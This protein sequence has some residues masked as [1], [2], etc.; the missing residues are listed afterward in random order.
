MMGG[1]IFRSLW[2]SY[3]RREREL[4][5]KFD[6]SLSFQDAMFD[7]WERA[8]RLGF[9]EGASIYNSALV[10]GEVEVGANS[11]IGPYTLLD[12][13]AGIK[14]GAWCAISA[15]TQIY[16]HHNVKRMLSGGRHAPYLGPISIGDCCF[17][18]SQT[19]IDPNVTIGDHCLVAAN[20]FVN[21][22]H[23]SFTIIA[24]TPATAIGRV[25][26]AGDEVILHYDRHASPEGQNAVPEAR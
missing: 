13:G 1:L 10:Y 15:G 19:I 11:W 23:P 3:L 18:G 2:R 7:R 17:I 25:E 9:G 26:L 8:R 4:R 5:E 14:I 21:T 16:T 22:S 6:R 20:S 12:G 24:G